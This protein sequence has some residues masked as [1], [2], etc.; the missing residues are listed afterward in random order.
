ML[1]YLDFNGT[2]EVIGAEKAIMHIL[3]K[4]ILI[5]ENIISFVF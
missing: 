1:I 5:A 2:K 4:Y 3:K